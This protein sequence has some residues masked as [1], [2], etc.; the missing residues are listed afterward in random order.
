MFNLDW[1]V[2]LED[3]G[4]RF[5]TYWQWLLNAWGWTAAVAG[6]ALV[7]ALALGLV[8]GT[9]RTLPK[10]PVLVWFGDAWVEIFRNIPIL[11]QVFIW[12]HVAPA[13][14]PPLRSTPSFVLVVCALG[15]FTSARIAEQVRAGIESLSRGQRLA[16]QALGFTMPQTYRF[17]LL[18]MALRI[19]IPPLTSET[20]NIVKNS[21]VAFA[22]SIPEL[23]M[24][25]MQVQEETSRGI[26]VYL[27]V[28]VLYIVTALAINR[29]MAVIEERT[30]IPGYVGNRG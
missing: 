11:V 20:M 5:P 2:F 4:G 1:R 10:Y 19:I 23:T 15:L 18:P 21:S 26:E 17:V 12:Y 25:A 13:L 16:G 22:V 9:L 27:A 28:T 3:P 6:A 24:F 29:V 7:L 8:I 30:R 14:V